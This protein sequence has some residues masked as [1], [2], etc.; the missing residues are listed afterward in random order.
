VGA[1]GAEAVDGSEAKAIAANMAKG[2]TKRITVL[3]T[4]RAD[5]KFR[6]GTDAFSLSK[7]FA[8]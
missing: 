5:K 4:R 8:A 1:A 7:D 3:E 2:I 6:T